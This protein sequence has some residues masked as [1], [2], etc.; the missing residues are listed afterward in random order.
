MDGRIKLIIEGEEMEL[1]SD[2]QF[3]ITKQ[4]TDISNPTTI[5]NDWSKTVNI[6]FTQKNN[7]IFGHIYNI[8]RMLP[9]STGTIGIHFDPLKKLDFRLE[10]CG[11]VVM[12][13]YAKLNNITQTDGKGTYN[14]TLN[15]ELGRLF[16]E[17]KKITFDEGDTE[18]YYIDGNDYFTAT[19]TKELV[20]DC[21][22]HP[23]GDPSVPS[24]I[25]NWIGFAPC[26]ATDDDID[27]KIYQDTHHSVKEF[28]AV[29]EE[30]GFESKTG[31]PADNIIEDGISPRG[32]GEL[33]S[34][35][36]IPYI[37]FRKLFEIFK[38][39][40]E[41]VTGYDIRL[42]SGWS[43]ASHP[44][45]F[46]K[47][48]YALRRFNTE[49]NLTYNNGYGQT[50]IEFNWRFNA[51]S[52]NRDFYE[53]YGGDLQSET[54]VASTTE[55]QT[56][57]YDPATQTFSP[58]GKLGHFAINGLTGTFTAR[59]EGGDIM[60]PSPVRMSPINY[61]L[62]NVKAVKASDPSVTINSKTVC[63]L[64]E[65]CTYDTSIFDAEVRIQHK[66]I[67]Q[68]GDSITASFTFP[69]ITITT[70]EDFK[71]VVGAIWWDDLDPLLRLMRWQRE[72]D[73]EGWKN[74]AGMDMNFTETGAISVDVTPNYFRT[75]NIFTINDLWDNEYN[76]FDEI[77]KYTKAYGLLWKVDNMRK[78]IDILPRAKYFENWDTLDWTDKIVKSK[79]FTI[80]PVAFEDKYV[81]FNYED[82]DIVLNKKYKERYGVNYGEKR[83]VTNYNFNTETKE[84]FENIRNAIAY[85]P[86]ILSWNSLEPASGDPRIYYILPKEK[87]L[88]CT[89]DEGKYVDV[90]G[91]LF[92]VDGTQD[93]DD[94]GQLRSVSISDDTPYQIS[95]NTYCYSQTFNSVNITKFPNITNVMDG[96]CSLFTVPMENY[97]WDSGSY[98]DA[99]G[100]YERYWK[101]YLDE[102]YDVKNKKVT[103][104]IRIKPTDYI[105]FEF[106]K[107]IKIGNQLFFVN[108]IENFDIN[109]TEPTKVELITIQN[110]NNY[111]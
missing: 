50:G 57:I 101:T 65:D 54:F 59:W 108:K 52:S 104:Y 96:K 41:E 49:N 46:D 64:D 62:V 15:G 79:D 12:S 14:I 109:N 21:F 43:S 103:C 30:S 18:G 35:K 31:I 48:C 47:L 55:E 22:E 83:L 17:M 20:K 84:L 32:L 51:E 82:S 69:E 58:H 100:L 42:D 78:I 13:G 95:N 93:I 85:T 1:D 97:T 25:T 61:L 105:S 4:F 81:M 11:S 71:I 107:F 60:T 5:I 106:N 10:W 9:I 68:R 33:R 99:V 70:S 76:L 26:T 16:Q 40:A 56:P 29:L 72:D 44:E 75:G 19:M 102:V 73:V 66:W 2:V 53:P 34:Y 45:N 7:Q 90:F 89:D 92:L 24:S 98:D 87:Y 28:T 67:S 38:D 74:L 6:P 27:T 8:D 88:C 111:V 110:P 86:N 91:S 39:K 37:H 94:S 63:I 80:I 36:Q 23:N 3:A 77:L